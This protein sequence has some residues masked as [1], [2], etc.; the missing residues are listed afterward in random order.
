MALLLGVDTGGTFTDAVLYDEAKGAV[1]AKAK[2]LTTHRDLAVG[3]AGAID[4]VLAEARGAEVALVSLS[5]TLATNAL[6]EGQ[7]DAAALVLIGF[8]EADLDR[9]GLREALGGAPA[10]M[11]V[12]GHRSD[13]GEAAAFDA[14]ALRR[15]LAG[16]AGEVDALAVAGVFAVRNPAHETAARD[17]AAAELGLPVTC[18]HELSA[19]LG[20]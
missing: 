19:K 13:G 1:L 5:T 3:V 8:E 14:E 10:L 20:G 12:G 11:I 15:G 9:A 17:V 2:A 7:G 6:V 4:A 18:S 16:L